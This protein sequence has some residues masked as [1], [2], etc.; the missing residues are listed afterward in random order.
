MVY[1]F[2]LEDAKTRAT[3]GANWIASTYVAPYC[4]DFSSGSARLLVDG[5][6]VS[7]SVVTEASII[8]EI[9][10]YVSFILFNDGISNAQIA[11]LVVFGEGAL[12]R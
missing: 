9:H 8:R 1:C 12:D 10:R 2:S 3:H 11:E 4:T 7:S 6:E 5:I